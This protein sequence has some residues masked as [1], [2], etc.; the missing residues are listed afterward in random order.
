MFNRREE[1]LRRLRLL[2]LELTMAREAALGINLV[3]SAK[4]IDFLRRID[5]RLIAELHASALPLLSADETLS[6]T[7]SGLR[8]QADIL[9][10]RVE[11]IIP[12]FWEPRRLQQYAEP[13]WDT[14]IPISSPAWTLA[15][16][17]QEA[18][19]RLCALIGDPA[20]KFRESHE[21]RDGF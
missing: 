4:K 14:F 9:N 18:I 10:F 13:N 17:F 2:V 20:P 8:A 16:R 6:E 12:L 19:K 7:L 21:I 15:G 1:T 5:T 3:T 11:A